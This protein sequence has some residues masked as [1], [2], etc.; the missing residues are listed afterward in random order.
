MEKIGCQK[1]QLAEWIEFVVEVDNDGMERN[2]EISRSWRS[3]EDIL[4]RTGQQK[5]YAEDELKFID[6]ER[7]QEESFLPLYG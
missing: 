2:E 5:Q 6:S 3:A 4:N 7:Y 1:T